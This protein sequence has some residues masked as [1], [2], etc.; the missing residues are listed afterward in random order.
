MTP[1]EIRQNIS[2]LEKGPILNTHVPHI[3]RSEWKSLQNGAKMCILYTI[4]EGRTVATPAIVMKGNEEDAIKE[5][6]KRIE[7]IEG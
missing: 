2:P 1:D 4:K 7:I 5:A 6:I 3:F